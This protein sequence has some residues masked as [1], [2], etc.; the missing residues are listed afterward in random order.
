MEPLTSPI[1][2]REAPPLC[3]LF[4]FRPFVPRAYI[5]EYPFAW[6]IVHVANTPELM[7]RRYESKAVH[8]KRLQYK[9]MGQQPMK[10]V[11]IV[12][13]ISKTNRILL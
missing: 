11:R 8:T 3:N 7:T 4:K 1:K 2:L 12:R 13:S 9:T 5:I 10:M 6:L